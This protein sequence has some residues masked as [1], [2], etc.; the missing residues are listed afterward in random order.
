[1]RIIAFLALK[2]IARDRKIVLLVVF[3]LAFSYIN[4][5]F[6]PAFLNGLSD[7]FQ[8][9]VIDTGTSHIIIQPDSQQP[10]LNF[11]SALRKKIDL[12]PGVVRSSSHLSLTGTVYYKGKQM[13][14]RIDSSVP[15]EDKEVTTIHKKIIKGDFLSDTSDGEIVLGEIIA[16]RKIEDTIGKEN[17]FGNVIEGLG[18]V[19]IGDKV[20][21]KFFNGVE[22]E[23]KVRGIA[24]GMGFG[25][26]SQLVFITKREA[27]KIV[28]AKD[29][30]SSILVKLNDKEDAPRYK[31]VILGLGIPNAKIQT[32]SEASSFT[33]GIKQTFEVVTLVTTLVGVIIVMATIGIVIFINT[34]RK[35]RIIGVLKAI[36]MQKSQITKIFLFES[37][38]FG[39][40]GTL[41]GIAFVYS[42]I[43]YF[44]ANPIDVPIGTLKP[45]LPA[46]TAIK[47]VIILIASSVIAGYV[48]ARMASKHDIL[49]SIRVVE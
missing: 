39:I 22:K 1:M 13:T 41:I 9:E 18:G 12:I 47:A 30:A 15:S 14:I 45:A 25:S 23:Y 17:A 46:E 19:D 24:G 29:K 27:E 11:E 38:V 32:W 3:L 36:G 43:I 5:T 6:F 40:L 49:E 20:R 42:S 48:P 10:Y 34:A 33:E 37:I 31:Q 28:G 7:T 4:L 16:G 21:V 35:R 2:D 44:N 8:N 26:V